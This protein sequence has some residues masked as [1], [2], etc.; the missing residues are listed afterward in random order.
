MSCVCLVV[1]FRSLQHKPL[2]EAKL[3]SWGELSTVPSVVDILGS[4]PAFV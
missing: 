2:P 3:W 1:S 4:T